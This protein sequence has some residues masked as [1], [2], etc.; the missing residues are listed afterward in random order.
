MMNYLAVIF[1]EKTKTIEYSE[2]DNFDEEFKNHGDIALEIIDMLP[3]HEKLIN[4]WPL[5]AHSIDYL[6]KNKKKKK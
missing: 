5:F 1:N 4:F 3:K 6:N 2:F